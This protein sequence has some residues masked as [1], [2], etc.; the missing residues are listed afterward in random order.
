MKD[1]SPLIIHLS[2]KNDIS[3]VNL[4]N[5]IISHSNKSGF[6]KDILKRVMIEEL[7]KNSQK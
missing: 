7:D 3:D 6:I 1:N 5:W 2:F 4:Y